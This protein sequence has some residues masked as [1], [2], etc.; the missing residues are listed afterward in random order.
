MLLIQ[1]LSWSPSR[2]NLGYAGSCASARRVAVELVALRPTDLPHDLAYPRWPAAR[3]QR[4]TMVSARLPQVL[5]RS[6]QGT[7]C[8]HHDPGRQG[9]G[10][11]PPWYRPLATTP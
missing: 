7:A 2:P 5:A 10:P 3:R 8:S 4:A 11:W 9:I 6:Y 1:Y